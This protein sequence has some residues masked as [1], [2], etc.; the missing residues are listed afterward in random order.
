MM[1]GRHHQ[2]LIKRH[3]GWHR[4]ARPSSTRSTRFRCLARIAHALGLIA[5]HTGLTEA[6]ALAYKIDHQTEAGNG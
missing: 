4:S 3:A 6:E 1:K 2:E 5:R